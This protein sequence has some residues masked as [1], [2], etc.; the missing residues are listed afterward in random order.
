MAVVLAYEETTAR[1]SDPEAPEGQLRPPAWRGVTCMS[2]RGQ[3]PT[4]APAGSC[5]VFRSKRQPEPVAFFRVNPFP[6]RPAGGVPAGDITASAAFRPVPSLLR[7][8]RHLHE[9]PARR[10]VPPSSLRSSI[11]E[12][13]PRHRRGG[14][15]SAPYQGCARCYSQRAAGAA[16][17]EKR[18][19]VVDASGRRCE[20]SCLFLLRRSRH[21]ECPVGP[22]T[23]RDLAATAPFRLFPGGRDT[24]S[25]LQ[26]RFLGAT[27]LKQP[28]SASSRGGRD[29]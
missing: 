11:P 4:P 10:L 25:P 28:H 13:Q 29:S 3:R 23:C 8:L 18:Q 1:P 6:P 17:V 19:W 9:V 24:R 27:S 21:P 7:C 26:G 22:K 2:A 12:G 20:R 16:I 15:S 14:G 5:L